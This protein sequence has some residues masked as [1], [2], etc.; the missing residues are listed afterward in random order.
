MSI[1]LGKNLEGRKIAVFGATSKIGSEFA[2]EAMRRGAE[3]D[4]T[5]L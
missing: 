4:D 2:I 1:E 5:S 3:M